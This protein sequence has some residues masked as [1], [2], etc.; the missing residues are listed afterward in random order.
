[1]V[2][3]PDIKAGVIW[4]G[5]VASYEDLLQLW[6]VGAE[7]G[8][9]PEGVRV[10]GD[11]LLASFGTP[12]DNPLFWSSISANSYVRDLSGPIQLHHGSGDTVV[13]LAFSNLL[14]ED[15]AAVDGAVS[16]F[17]YPGDDHSLTASFETAMARSIAFF[18]AQV[19]N[20]P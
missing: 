4:S 16:Y 15:I 12:Q 17:A 6:T 19:K 2:V 1:M 9:I 18:D 20:A 13:P 5:V 7:M 11:Q 3:A 8:L 14:L 10:W